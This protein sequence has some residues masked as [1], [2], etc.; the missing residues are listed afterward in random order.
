MNEP[1]G[2]DLKRYA[3]GCFRQRRHIRRFRRRSALD[4]GLHHAANTRFRALTP[5]GVVFGDTG[6]SPL[7]TFAVALGATGHAIPAAADV[8]GIVSLIFW[9]LMA[10]VS[11]NTWCS[12]W[13]T[14]RT[15]PI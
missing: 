3:C 15:N 12:W 7:Y 2:P 11:L 5:L 1:A 14:V 9:A 13:I 6:T 8:L 10:T 4:G